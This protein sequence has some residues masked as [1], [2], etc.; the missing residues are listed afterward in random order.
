M[1]IIIFTLALSVY[2]FTGLMQQTTLKT[3]VKNY[4]DTIGSEL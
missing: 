4:L 3:D 2:M 1:R